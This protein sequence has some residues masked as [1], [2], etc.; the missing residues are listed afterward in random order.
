MTERASIF[1]GPEVDV[2]DFAPKAGRDVRPS[3]DEID[4]TAGARF[5]SRE[6]ET[7]PVVQDEKPQRRKP[8][9]YRTGRNVVFSVKT[10]STTTER[11]YMLAEQNGWK[12]VET[13]EKAVEALERELDREAG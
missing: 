13:F 8:V 5:R 6:P 3:P 9:V 4:R 10:T 2:S 1:S 11:F 7:A 12:A